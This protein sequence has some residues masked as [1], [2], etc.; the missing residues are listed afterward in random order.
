MFPAFAGKAK[1]H[2]VSIHS[3]VPS[4]QRGQAITIVVPGIVVVADANEGGFQ[5]MNDGRKDFLAW[6]ASKGHVVTNLGADSRESLC[7]R[8]DML[9]FGAL[10]DLAETR[11]VAV[12][13]A[14]LGITT[15]S[16][17]MTV[18]KGSDP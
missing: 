16:L 12:L 5:E 14:T 11:M 1:S 3:R 6:K 18:S 7:E 10:A 15:G 4:L 17:N 8:D 13:L 9:V 2:L